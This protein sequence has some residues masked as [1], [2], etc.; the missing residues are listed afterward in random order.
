M[1]YRLGLDIG[2]AS[3]GWSVMEHDEKDNPCRIVDLGVRTFTPA[4]KPKTG[5]SPAVDRRNARGIRRTLRRRRE[6]LN[7]LATFLRTN[8]LDGKEIDFSLCDI[9]ELRVNALDKKVTNNE[10]SRIIYHIAKHRGFK[11]NRKAEIA[12]KDGKKLKAAIDKMSDES[13]EYRSIGEMY[14]KN[15]NYYE[16]RQKLVGDEIKTYKR[17][18]TRNKA[19]MYDKTLLRADV[20]KELEEILNCQKA[21]GNTKIDN[22]FISKVLHIVDYQK[23]YDEGP[24]FPS[25]YHVS[26][27]VGDCTFLKG[28]KRAPKASFTYEYFTALC[29]INNL[30]INEKPIDD[31]QRQSLIDKFL[32]SKEIKYKDVKKLLHLDESVKISGKSGSNKDER[33]FV[34]RHASY[35]ILKY[36]ELEQTPKVYEDIINAVAY[37]LSMF[38]S[39]ERRMTYFNSCEKTQSLTVDQKQHLCE[40]DFNKFGN[41]SIKAMQLMIP[42][43]EKGEK[44]TEASEHAGLAIV[45]GDRTKKLKYSMLPELNDLT[46]P[47]VKRAVS[48]TIKVVNA[49]IDKYGSPCAVFVELGRDMSNDYSERKRIKK[50]N[51]DNFENNE[52]IVNELK[53]LGITNPGGQDIVKMKLYKEQNGKCAYSGKSLIDVFGSMQAIFAKDNTQID[54]IIP[55]SRCYD[56]SLNNKVLVLSSENQNKG[57]RLPYE[58]F[59]QD[60]E[61]WNKFV[62]LS[63]ANYKSNKRKLENL[64]RKSLTKDQEKELNNRA[65]NDTR[66][67]CKFMK[68]LLENH[69]IFEDSRL[70]N[71]P[72]RTVNGRM[73]SFLRKIWG[74]KKERFLNDKHHA[75]DATIVACTDQ[76]MVERV[77][78]FLQAKAGRAKDNEYEFVD[79][80]TGE[81]ISIEDVI[82]GYD[83]N[84]QMPYDNLKNEIEIRISDNVLSRKGELID[85]GYTIENTDSVRPLYVSRMVNHKV[86]GPIHE[87][88]IRSKKLY[89]ENSEKPY[90]VTRT[91]LTKLKLDKNNE[92]E[93]YPQKF[94]E[95][96]RKLYEA[97]R[98]RLLEF[99]NDAKKA[100]AEPFYKPAKNP[101]SR[102]IVRT[103]KLQ[104]VV[105]D[106]I[107]I[108]KGVASN[109]SMIRIDLFERNNK[110]YFI[111]VYTGD[112][113]R[114]RL[115]NKLCKAATSYNNWTELDDTYHFM[116]SLYQNDLIKV[117][118]KKGFNFK[119]SDEKKAKDKDSK[120][121]LN[122]VFAYYNCAGR[123]TASIKIETIDGGFVSESVGIQNLL[124]LEKYEID[125]LGNIRRVKSEKRRE[126]V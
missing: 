108:N 100:F 34:K 107:Y 79:I 10:L 55:Y 3:V 44:Y 96:D 112:Y 36:L 39:D 87:D 1:K 45:F 26:F 31:E 97:L 113:Y 21:F 109:A 20:L 5:E 86:T 62:A 103:V 29:D 27:N 73:T 56:D 33:V 114:K 24:D 50:Q 117:S 49:I 90:V 83:K 84:Y 6:R 64:F 99:D 74:I 43:L 78:R 93:N 18:N 65:L 111:P 92:I 88:T 42:F 4:E 81:I 37:G 15:E 57:Q 95:D 80:A 89:D 46:S 71:R 60:E 11:S 124:K 22:D 53:E 115:P 54:H 52:K 120:I 58:Y 2:I 116:F 32:K 76:G 23:S 13:K 51:E 9:Y 59:G 118:S 69:L 102:N 104:S 85:I 98:S 47:V 25:P 101:E 119:L 105:S 82:K 91:P 16:I 122:D 123:A 38:K 68:N 28:E 48:Q 77:S 106:P 70:K 75:V 121:V 72:V 61:K 12:D 8:L 94:K 63:L 7:K 35:D 125:I 67:I 40:L 19:G 30:S 14:V 126:F 66:Y 41:L 17:Y 110:Y